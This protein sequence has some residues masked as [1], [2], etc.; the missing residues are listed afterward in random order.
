MTTLNELKPGEK[1]II[2]S[3]SNEALSSKLIDMGCLPGELVSI[4]RLAPLGCPYMIHVSGYELSLRKAEA[5]TV[6]VETL[7]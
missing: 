6:V 5:M 4:S 1:A 7:S 2:R 3:F